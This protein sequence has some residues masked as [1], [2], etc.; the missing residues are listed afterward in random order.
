MNQLLHVPS[1]PTTLLTVPRLKPVADDTW[2]IRDLLVNT[3]Q[4]GAR[5]PIEFPGPS[6][7]VGCRAI[8][9]PNMA[10]GGLIVPTDDD[11]LALVDLDNQRRFTSAEGQ[12]TAAGIG[13]SFT[14]LSALDTRFR[15]L[16][17]NLASPRPVLGVTFRWRSDTPAIFADAL[18]SLAFFVITQR[19]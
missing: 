12:G 8:V 9:R 11:I 5:I 3:Q 4:Q 15:D 18:C 13:S 17:W 19:S 14:T 7:V 10:P 6:I 16:N 2:E 1:E